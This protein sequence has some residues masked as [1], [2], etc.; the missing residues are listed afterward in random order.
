MTER[1]ETERQCIVCN[2]GPTEPMIQDIAFRQWTNKGYVLCHAAVTIIVCDDCGA[3]FLDEEAE[4][5]IE[6][7]ANRAIEENR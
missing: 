2:R 4:S 7:V 5:I 3:K 6:A 1:K